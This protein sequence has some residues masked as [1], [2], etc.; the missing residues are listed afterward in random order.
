[1]N[2]PVLGFDYGD[3]RIGIAIGEA[4][5]RSARPLATVGQDWPRIEALLREW[6]PSACVV[7]LPLTADGGEQPVTTR[8]RQFAAALR[9]RAGVP[10]HTCDERHSSLAAASEIKI[11]RAEGRGA[12]QIDAVAACLILEQWLNRNTTISS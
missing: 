10:V 12:S 5:T 9:K 8:A 2:G 7:G 3:K 1:M 6:R 11:R 4:L